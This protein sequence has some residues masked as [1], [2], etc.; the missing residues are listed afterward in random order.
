LL[1]VTVLTLDQV[2]ILSAGKIGTFDVA[3]VS[4]GPQ[5]RT[6]A[7]QRRKVLRIWRLST[8]FATYCCARCGLQG[9]VRDGRAAAMHRAEAVRAFVE[10]SKFGA[11]AVAERRRKAH[12]LWNR[13]QP[14]AGSPV[15]RYLRE[16]R[17]Y[18][19]PIPRTIGFLPGGPG[20][21]PAMI[22]VFALLDELELAPIGA[23]SVMAVHITRLTPDGS[24]KAGTETDK[25]MIGTP[26]GTPIVLA[27]VNDGLGLAVTE[28]IESGLSIF[29]AT[30]LGVWAAGSAPFLPALADKIPRYVETVSIVADPDEAG[31]RFANDLAISLR[32]RD[33]DHRIIVWRDR[34]ATA[35]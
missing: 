11:A 23:G 18:H 35:A 31:R 34:K 2:N 27:P 28:G 8:T 32:G 22:T 19:G 12:W 17:G 21:A 16:A 7:N 33:I 3:C 4:C 9:Y 20:F 10:A 5:C 29:D 13:R 14:A 6:P 30:G 26:R 25:I 15:E 1:A 24:A